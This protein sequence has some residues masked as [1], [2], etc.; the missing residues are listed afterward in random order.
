MTSFKHEDFVRF[1]VEYTGLDTTS[2]R[3]TWAQRETWDWLLQI[4]DT[5]VDDPQNIDMYYVI[6]LKDGYL[7]DVCIRAVLSMIGRHHS[8]RTR[9]EALPSGDVIQRVCG[10]GHLVG[11]TL[12]CTESSR[13]AAVSAAVGF[14]TEEAIGIHGEQPLKVGLICVDGYARNMVVVQSRITVD[15]GGADAFK[16]ELEHVLS[17]GSAELDA[18][19]Q[20]TIQRQF[21]ESE[22]GRRMNARS[23]HYLERLLSDIP[24]QQ[25]S[26][27]HAAYGTTA[28][29]TLVLESPA[30]S[31]AVTVLSHDL[32]VSESSIILAAY[33]GALRAKFDMSEVFMKIHVFNRYTREQVSSVSRLKQCA[34]FRSGAGQGDF[35]RDANQ[36]YGR[37]LIAYKNGRYDPQMLAEIICEKGLEDRAS[38][39]DSW[40]FNDR[41]SPRQRDGEAE[42]RAPTRPELASLRGKRHS[43]RVVGNGEVSVSPGMDLNVEAGGGRL[44]LSLACNFLRADEISELLVRIEDVVLG[45]AVERL[46]LREHG[47]RS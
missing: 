17:V 44:W 12:E 31:C 27:F 35:V 24:N 22:A 47:T 18:P 28:L 20:P 7:R 43:P 42:G 5:P 26:A 1:S 39:V 36:A 6:D 4:E 3:L 11:G 16:E 21:E 15:G 40:H 13:Q 14:L 25:V 9:F 30:L 37:A 19:Y 10:D 34:I 33:V 32:G 2:S 23:L 29:Q 38:Y 45:A 8:L 46:A 41:R